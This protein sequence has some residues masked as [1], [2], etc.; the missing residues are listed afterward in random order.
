MLQMRPMTASEFH[1]YR[2]RAI[3]GYASDLVS[4][5][6]NAVEDAASRRAPVSTRCCR[7][8]CVPPARPSSCS[9][10]A[11]AATRWATSGTRSCL[12]GRTARCSSTTSTSPVPAPP[13]LGH[14]YARGA[15]CRGTPVRRH[16]D[17]AVGVQSQRGG[18]CAVSCVRLRADHDDL[19]QASHF[20]LKP[21]AGAASS[22]AGG[23]TRRD[24]PMPAD[25]TI[26]PVRQAPSAERPFGRSAHVTGTSPAH[27]TGTRHRHV[28]GTRHRA[29]PSISATATRWSRR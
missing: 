26:L 17:R 8:A 25:L 11:P 29:R 4:S 5:G 3:D 13:G 21:P 10:T 18:P 22:C 7:T 27:V 12:K 16:R 23:S 19:D 28:T 24:R 2:T 20:G 15:R 9:S 14:A 6:Q 1:A